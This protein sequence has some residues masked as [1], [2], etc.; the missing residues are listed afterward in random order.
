MRNETHRVQVQTQSYCTNPLNIDMGKVLG[1]TELSPASVIRTFSSCCPLE[2][3]KQ[4]FEL[5][6]RKHQS[7]NSE[8]RR[9]IMF[10]F[11]SVVHEIMELRNML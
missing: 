10:C 4:H 7:S 1:D 11:F 5:L 3:T 6:Q 9:G 2:V 8:E